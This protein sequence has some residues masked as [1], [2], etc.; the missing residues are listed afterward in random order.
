MAKRVSISEI[1]LSLSIC[2]SLLL[3]TDHG[4]SLI[5]VVEKL[6]DGPHNP[7]EQTRIHRLTEGIPRG[8]GFVV[9]QMNHKLFPSGGEGKE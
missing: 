3:L 6:V 1:S 2:L 8:D 5:G 4:A 7:S 9:F